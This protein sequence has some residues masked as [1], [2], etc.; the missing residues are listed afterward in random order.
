[1]IRVILKDSNNLVYFND[2]YDVLNEQ[3]VNTAQVEVT[4]LDVD[5]VEVAG[6]EWPVLL[7]YQTGSN[8]DYLQVLDDDI[9]L[10]VG[11]FYV[12]KVE[13]DDGPGRR[14]V[15]THELEIVDRQP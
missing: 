12:A 14:L 8:G 10:E 1:M 6:E 5:G 2:L 4:L 9:V 7:D 15:E 3:Y 11:K 13:I